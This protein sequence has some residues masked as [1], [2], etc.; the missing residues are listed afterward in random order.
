MNTAISHLFQLRWFG[1]REEA[2]AEGHDF[3]YKMIRNASTNHR[4]KYF[5]AP[6]S[7]LKSGWEYK[8]FAPEKVEWS[9][10]YWQHEGWTATRWGKTM[11][12]YRNAKCPMCIVEE[13]DPCSGHLTYTLSPLDGNAA[14]CNGD[15]TWTLLQDAINGAM[16]TVEFR[17]DEVTRPV[18]QQELVG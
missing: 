6:K 2:Y 18:R 9:E 15:I 14:V 13:A 3:I 8:A 1:S 12:I 5:L 10:P 7:S 4:Q 17:D 11:F 16:A